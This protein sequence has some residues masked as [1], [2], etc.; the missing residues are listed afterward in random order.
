MDTR[1]SRIGRVEAEDTFRDTIDLVDMHQL[2]VFLHSEVF[3][4]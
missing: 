2:V 4:I 1:S 3:S